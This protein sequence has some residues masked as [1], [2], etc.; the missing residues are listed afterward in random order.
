[1]CIRDRSNAFSDRIS[2]S[3]QTWDDTTFEYHHSDAPN[4]EVAIKSAE[5]IRQMIP[6]PNLATLFGLYSNGQVAIVDAEPERA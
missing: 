4:I 3:T 2:Q 5:T 1:M 6:K